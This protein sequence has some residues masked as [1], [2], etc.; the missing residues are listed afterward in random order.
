MKAG[1][2]TS[3]TASMDQFHLLLQVLQSNGKPLMNGNFTGRAIAEVVQKYTGKNPIEV[4]VRN[5]Q[6]AIVQFDNG[7][8]VGEA[9]RLLHGTH[10]WL[11]QVVRI[12]CLLSTRE[13]IEGVVDDREK[14]RSRLVELEKDQQRVQQEQERVRVEQAAH[15]AHLE[16]VLAQFGHEVQKVEELQ[17]NAMA[18]ASAHLMSAPPSAVSITGSHSST[19]INKPPALSNFSGSDPV[20]KDEGSYEQWKFQVTGALKVFTEEAVR[21]AIVRS[22]RGEVREMISFLGFDGDL[23]DILEKVEKRFGKQLSG[24]RLQQEFYQLSQEKSEKDSPIRW[25]PGTEV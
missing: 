5:E 9:A 14:G 16:R 25:S 23:S 13:S 11:G 2:D 15:A 6:D 18:A 1:N 4:E 24:D 10:D 3:I 8:S 7:V 19:K 22:V 21:S 20:P 17:R 12:S